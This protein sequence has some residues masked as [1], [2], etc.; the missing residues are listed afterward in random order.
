MK[1]EQLMVAEIYDKKTKDTNKIVIAP[2]GK[3]KQWVEQDKFKDGTIAFCILE[4]FAGTY[5][6]YGI[7]RFAILSIAPYKED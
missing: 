1:I 7:E 6:T 5:Y 3:N 4:A 2:F